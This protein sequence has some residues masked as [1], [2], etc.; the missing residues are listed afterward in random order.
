[1]LIIWKI[2]YVDRTDKQ[3]RNRDLRL[4][5]TTLPPVE[6]AAVELLAESESSRHD[7]EFLK[8]KP[9]FRERRSCDVAEPR[10]G[11]AKRMRCFSLSNYFEDE[12]GNEL[13]AGELGL[14]L[15]GSSSAIVVPSGARQHDIDYMLA[16][17]TSVPIAEVVLSADDMRV[18]GYFVRDFEQ[19]RDSAF[20][21]DGAGTITVGGLLPDLPN[22]DYH[23][24]TAVSD[25]EIRS[26]MMIFRRLYMEKEPAN[27]AKATAVFEKYLGEHPTGKWVAGTFGE[28]ASHLHAPPECNSLMQSLA[29]S[30]SVKRLI[31]VYLY[32]QYAHQPDERRQ[33][34]FSEC[35]QQVAGKRNFLTWLFLTEVWKCSLEI[36]NAGNPIAYWFKRYCDHHGITPDVLSSLRAIHSGIGTSEKKEV[37]N[38][39]LFRE[40][41][42]ELELELWKRADKPEGG[43][44]L[45]RLVAQQQLRQALRGSEES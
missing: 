30:F 15:T 34:Q 22:E 45:F 18:L 7:R 42:E 11:D 28:Y 12:E 40:K 16:L 23:F 27:F 9:L 17:K 20:M 4:D 6:R 3:F 1:M 38:A 13:T 26:F 8:F 19:L 5:T 10:V 32:T 25:D 14:I 33:R 43:P 31:D 36:C 39:R 44:M 37:R 2:S 24:S 29:I 21:K 35:L 41:V